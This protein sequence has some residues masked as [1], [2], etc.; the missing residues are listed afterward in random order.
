MAILA[1]R[2]AGCRNDWK[3]ALAG[4]L[5]LWHSRVLGLE[6]HWTHWLEASVTGEFTNEDLFSRCFH[7]FEPGPRSSIWGCDLEG[8]GPAIRRDFELKEI[9]HRHMEELAPLVRT[10]KA[11][12]FGYL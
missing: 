12:A 6:A 1:A 2:G 7:D 3:T 11:K 9:R 5:L 10:P 8:D 4:R